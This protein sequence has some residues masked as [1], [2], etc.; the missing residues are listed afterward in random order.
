[1]E[2]GLLSILPPFVAITLALIFKNVFIALF[3]GVF[4]GYVILSGG[5]I[6]IGL[7]QTL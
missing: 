1:M 2:Y 5:N 3:T 4:L 6:F 7:H